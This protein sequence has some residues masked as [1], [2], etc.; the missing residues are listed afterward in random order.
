MSQ[1]NVEI[2]RKVTE[3]FNRRDKDAWLALNDPEVVFRA[4]PEWPESATVVGS[5]AVWDFV[6]SL[7]DTWEPGDYEIVEAIEV[8]DDTIAARVRRP[9]QG[10][11]SGVPD[12]LDYW[13][14]STLRGGKTVRSIWFVTRAEALEAAGLVE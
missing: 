12:V 9:V 1:E 5:E 11:A 4:A 3:A 6:V 14:V 10:R 13:C 2:V 8:G 7:D